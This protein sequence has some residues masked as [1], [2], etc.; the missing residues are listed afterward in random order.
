[1][2]RVRI[3]SYNVCYTKLLRLRVDGDGISKVA[4]G[5]LVVGDLLLVKPGEVIPADGVVQSG[6]SSVNQSTIT[7]ESIPVDK[8]IG[9]EVYAGTLNGQGALRN[10]FV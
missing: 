3:T 8:G 4:V 2:P 10:N 5:E 7:G 9:N 6:G 1:M